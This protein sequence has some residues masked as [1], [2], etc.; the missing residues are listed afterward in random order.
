[1]GVIG[2]GGL[3]DMAVKPARALGALVVAGAL[4]PMA[5]VNNQEVAFHR[6]SVAGSL[7]GSIEETR[8]VLDFCAEHGI[9]PDVQFVRIQDVNE[10]FD[11]VE[12]GE[13]RFRC[14]IDMAS[15]KGEAA[16]AG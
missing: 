9:G 2:L 1:M 11:S 6:R 16:A 5:A 4:E 13:V 3:G 10:A 12:R 7:I 15:L 14:V 8:E